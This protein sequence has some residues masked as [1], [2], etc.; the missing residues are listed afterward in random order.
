[1]PA[2]SQIMRKEQIL[3]GLI[4]ARQH[5]LRSVKA[6]S[7]KERDRTFLGIWSIKDLLAHLVGWD[8]T[9]V[10]AIKAVM[11]GSLPSFYAHHDHDWRKYNSTLVAK[12]KRDS[13][14]EL[15]GLLN[16]SHRELIEFLKT[17]PA[18][19]FNK[20]FGVRFRGYK[21]TIQRLLEAE[22]KD[23]RIHHKQITDFFKE[24]K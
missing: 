10:E 16:T 13:F 23:E 5:I 11:A 9:N 12:Y 14:R 21:V 8:H 24:P 2:N 22:A 20:D 17:I 3:G 7:N 19:V 15:L 1:M 6:I 18:E 4:E